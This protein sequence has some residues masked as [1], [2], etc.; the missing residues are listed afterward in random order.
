MDTP[1]RYLYLYSYSTL[2][3][4]P[5]RVEAYFQRGRVA[6]TTA[7]PLDETAQWRLGYNPGGGATASAVVYPLKQIW[8]T[9]EAVRAAPR[10][11]G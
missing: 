9:P 6:M 8:V 7:A 3:T 2:N 10:I 11:Y 4:S 1:N 5:A